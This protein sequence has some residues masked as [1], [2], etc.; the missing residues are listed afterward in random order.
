MGGTTAKICLIHDFTAQKG[1][2]FEVYRA[3]RF[4][5]GS[6]HPLRIPVVEMIEIG[7]GGGSIARVDHLKRLTVGPQS[8]ASV[9]GPACYQR[10][11]KE[12]TVTDA[13]LALG[14]IDPQGFAGGSIILNPKA[15][16]AALR[17]AIGAPLELSPER[18]A[19]GV[20][21]IVDENMANAARVHSVERGAVASDHVLIAFG[22]AAPLHAA[23]LAEKLGVGK[24]IIPKDAG[25]GSAVGFLK[26]PAAYE[27]VQSRYMRLDRFDAKAAN[28]LLSAMSAETRQH[29]E[30]AA[31]GVS[32]SERRLAYMRY[33]GQGHE[34][35]VE[36]P[37]TPLVAEE[38]PRLRDAFET[39]YR[40]LF[41]RHIPDAA[42][43]I[44]SWSVLST[45]AAPPLAQISPPAPKGAAT[46]SGTRGVFDAATGSEIEIPTYR[47]ADLR[48]GF[49]ISGPA[50]IVEDGTST[51][52][53]ARFDA[54]SDEGGALILTRKEAAR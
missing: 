24:L 28:A 15:A 9:P 33:A 27:L 35:A 46:P 43:E 32:L 23:R 19:Q 11:G 14:R 18:A 53:S 7:A 47:R 25:V 52:V 4:M 37:L 10:G 30:N 2:T 49:V 8:A 34:V 16:L 39:A 40:A 13:D 41:T 12:A 5:K 54:T 21:E 45:T 31:R 3:A 6:G 1:R 26:A 51:M 48:P 29:A 50:I 38:A 17:Q 36:L 44:L 22:G 42:I 20:S